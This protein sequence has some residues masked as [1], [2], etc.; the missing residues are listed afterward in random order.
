MIK[1]HLQAQCC[2]GADDTMMSEANMVPAFI[3]E[4]NIN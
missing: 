2:L 1:H 4:T 3:G